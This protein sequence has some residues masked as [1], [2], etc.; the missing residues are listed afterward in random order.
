MKNHFIFA[1]FVVAY[2]TTI[3]LAENITT[4]RSQLQKHGVTAIFP[5]DPAYANASA[6]FNMRF[7]FSPI[8]ITFPE[9]SQQ[10]SASIKAGASQDLNV[11]AR[12]GGHSYIAN[13]LG[14][15]N[16]SLVV[17]LS[18]MKAMAYDDEKE[19]M[20]IQTGN[21][22]GDI[23]LALNDHGRAIPH[24]RCT[25]VGI[26]GHSGHGG[27]GFASRM[28]GLN[29]DVVH[30][31]EVVLANGTIATVSESENPELFWGIRGSSS[32]FG[33]VTSIEF[34]TFPAPSAAT[35][36]QFN[37]SFN[38][39]E[40]TQALSNWQSFVDTDIPPQLGGEL[41][42]TRGPSSGQVNVQ[43]F[44]GYWGP[45][46]DF[47]STIAP[48]MNTFPTPQS[49]NVT[50][51]NWLEGLEALVFGAL[52][53]STMIESRDT[54]YAKSVMTPEQVPM[55]EEAMKA[56]ITYLGTEGISSNTSWFVEVELY[57]GSN[58][59]INAVPLD[60]TA[61][62]HR[63]TRFNL[64]LYASSADRLPPYP[65]DGFT[66]VEGMANS[67]IFNMPD[68]WDWASYVNY[69][70]ERL[71]DWQRLYYGSHY[72]RL[73]ALKHYVDPDDVFFFPESIEE[74]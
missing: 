50:S 73:Q 28:W 19:I 45:H 9:T 35:I 40:A 54:F 30:S 10:V 23:A 34:N 58:S 52:N 64:Q 22:L 25:Y 42:L 13:G 8:A 16:G 74:P 15:K 21:R 32:S 36:F 17:D 70:D 37:W 59:A 68:N 53:T 55:T 44:G 1:L 7:S 5:G 11:V 69:P 62:A 63:S 41:V 12:S 2:A 18:R 47:N 46:E 26:G 71:E 33:I 67:I 31:V 66:F 60:S 14:G 38:L 27:F 20:S 39:T 49:Q 57:G 4:L 24:G 61:F 43:F 3:S 6:A 56:F 48:F 29:L 65:S 72:E 51:G